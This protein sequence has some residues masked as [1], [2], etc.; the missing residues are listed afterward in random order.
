MRRADAW[1]AAGTF[2]L[3]VFSLLPSGLAP[4]SLPAGFGDLV[5]YHYPMRH[6][7]AT[8]LICGRMPF[9]NPYLFAGLPL[10]A[11]PQSALY[12]PPAAL[13]WLFPLT[14][15]LSWDC[16]L[17]LFWAALGA[18]LLAR[19]GGIAGVSAWALG[20]AYAACPFVAY[21]VVE[22]IPTLLAS[23]AW[24]PW[25]W[26][27]WVY[28]ARGLLAA[29]L[30]L[31]LLSG[32]PQ[33][34]AVNALGLAVWTA[35]T[36]PSRLR[37]LAF[38]GLCA[39]ALTAVLWAPLFEFLG[40]SVRRG[41]PASFSL[42]YSVGA[43][44]LSTWLWPGALGD[45][46]RKTWGGPPSVFLETTGVWLGPA[47][48]LSFA[49]LSAARAA[50]LAAGLFLA[51]G[52]HNP[53][54]R[55]LLEH[56]ALGFLRTPSRALFLD[57]WALWLSAGAGWLAFSRR[58]GRRTATALAAAGVVCM[59]VW[60]GPFLKA[61]DAYPLLA[62][63]PT[64]AQ[65]M[66]DVPFRIL[67]DPQLSNQ[68]KVM[69]Y[70]AMNVNGYEAF[71]L[72]GYPAYAARSEG[73][74]AAD[75]SRTYLTR[76]DTPEMRRLG[77]AYRLTVAGRLEKGGAKALPLAFFVDAKGE[78]VPGPVRLSR[79]RPERWRVE[80]AS[81]PARSA[82]LVLSQSAYPGWRAWLGGRPVAL[83][84]YDGLLQSVR[85]PD[86]AEPLN[87]VAEFSPSRYGLL[88][89]ATAAA[90]ALWLALWRR[91]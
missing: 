29:A 50:L 53:G 78:P 51:A 6:L 87:L 59:L 83:E 67:G 88:A 19:R 89:A 34:C 5:A 33:F 52:A 61:A 9:W 72:A 45:P 8:S 65:Q 66:G 71:Y 2:A 39:A 12:Y 31:Q 14:L 40:Q 48:F 24:A 76:A 62:I 22:G 73:G 41:W 55:W 85:R 38:E 26:L 68:N 60:D 13:G 44:E 4:W 3:L 28:G 30:A 21:R 63:N 69:L 7:I 17:H 27:F 23:L 11:N 49:G 54:Y 75:A 90:W 10:A 82:A 15:G 79:E 86:E 20:L 56:T 74:P 91:A 81:W 57:L 42:G 36:R 58:G 80:A 37:A 64:L 18:S 1:L 47:L 70:R 43:R 77:V 84:L 35:C 16:W 46:L 25:C 32:H